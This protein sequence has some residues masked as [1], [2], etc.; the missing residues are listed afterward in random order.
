MAKKVVIK[1]ELTAA[2]K[3]CSGDQIPSTPLGNCGGVATSILEFN[4]G[5]E[6]LSYSSFIPLKVN[7]ILM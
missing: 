5:E 6:H 3:K 7:I 2:V 4:S 1:Q